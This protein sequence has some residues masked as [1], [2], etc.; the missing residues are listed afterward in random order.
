MNLTMATSASG[1]PLNPDD[2]TETLVVHVTAPA[3]LP[4]GYT[5]E[6]E[7]NGDP[8]KVFTCDVPDGGVEEGQ[9]FLAPLPHDY[10]SPRLRAPIGTWKDG[11]CDWFNAGICHASLWCALCCTQIAMGQT[12]SR[13]QVSVPVCVSMR[14]VPQLD[15][16]PCRGSLCL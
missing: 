16:S 4:A 5:F 12:M 11:L 3:S 9:I 10:D 7:I 8:E 14:D 6:A 15:F 1:A 2:G 13:M